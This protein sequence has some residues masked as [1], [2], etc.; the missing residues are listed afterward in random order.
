MPWGAMAMLHRR[1]GIQFR[2]LNASKGPAVRAT[3]AQADRVLY[4]GAIRRRLETQPG[5][6][7]I[8]QAVDDLILEGERV[9]GAV[10]AI[11]AR[12]AATTVVL[13][14][15]TFLGGLVHVGLSNYRAG[16]AGDP[17]A[18]SL[19][20][21]LRELDLPVGRLKTG[22]PPR[23]RPPITFSRLGEGRRG[24]G[25]SPL[26]SPSSR[27]RDASAQVSFGHPHPLARTTS[28]VRAWTDRRCHTADRGSRPALLHLDRGQIH[29]FASN[30]APYLPSSP[31][32]HDRGY[33]PTLSS[34]SLPSAS[35]RL[36]SIPS[37]LE[38]ATCCARYASSTTT[39]IPGAQGTLDPGDRGPVLR[40]SYQ[41]TPIR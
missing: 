12:F 32:P 10:T 41:W 35:T 16:R 28:S 38:N 3:R 27:P 1:A 11:G 4:R 33:Y 25:R 14:A 15:G 19:A 13:T 26:F 5:L 36:L 7:I 24:T 2:T 30:L 29:R 17:P 39:S 37:L 31:R 20:A 22:T 40:P 18:L 6:W 8:Q 21:R 23:T 9:A 34:T